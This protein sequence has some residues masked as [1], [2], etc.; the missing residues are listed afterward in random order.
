MEFLATPNRARMCLSILFCLALLFTTSGC[1]QAFSKSYVA[2]I[3]MVMLQEVPIPNE[4]KKPE[5]IQQTMSHDSAISLWFVGSEGW[6]SD[7]TSQAMS[8]PAMY[9]S[10]ESYFEAQI[11]SLFLNI[12]A[13]NFE[14]VT[15]RGHWVRM[16]A[17][18]LPPMNQESVLD[19]RLPEPSLKEKQ[20]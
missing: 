5:A 13:L 19:S 20:P 7:A 6:E 15:L 1:T 11:E 14:S 8:N 2:F 10:N 12:I 3:P 4:A 16:V 17:Q 9:H 18:P